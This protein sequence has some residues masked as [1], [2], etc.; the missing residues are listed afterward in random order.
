MWH[1]LGEKKST[2]FRVENLKER[3]CVRDEGIDGRLIL[4]WALKH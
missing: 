3:D 1:T 4:K 2:E